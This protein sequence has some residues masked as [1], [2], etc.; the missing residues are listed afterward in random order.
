MSTQKIALFTPAGEVGRRLAE[1]ALKRGHT[2]TAIVTDEN[3][4]KLKH[5]NLKVVRGD[6][7]KKEEVT[8][9]AKGHDVV[10]NAYS[11]SI[12]NPRE[13]VDITRSVIEGTKEA[14]VQHIVSAS[15]PF[16]Q[17][18]EATEEFYN[19]FKPV[20]QAQQEALKLLQKE[21]NLSW[22]Y[23]HSVAPEAGKKPGEYQVSDEIYFS[24]PEGQARIP[25]KEYTSTLLNEAEK[26]QMETHEFN[27]E[28]RLE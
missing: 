27:Y 5:P 26:G 10:I 12:K 17:R 19:S 24:H 14:G 21:K 8:K 4:F 28:D 13:H 3:E 16:E 23:L 15:H 25:L 11:P 1:E 9:Y 6:V 18:M 7:R 2:V 20:I 22:S